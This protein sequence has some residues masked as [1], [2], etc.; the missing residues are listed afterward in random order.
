MDDDIVTRLR[1]VSWLAEEGSEVVDLAATAADEIE[2]LRALITEWV[3]AYS[4]WWDGRYDYAKWFRV[5]DRCDK[6]SD[7]LRK[8]AGQ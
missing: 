1:A 3:D 5:A 8:E 2:R 4:E 7:A 6:A